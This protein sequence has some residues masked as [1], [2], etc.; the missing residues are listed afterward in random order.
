MP[1]AVRV[2]SGI[3]GLV[4]WSGAAFC[5]AWAVVRLLGLEWG[6][7]AIQLLAFT[8]YVAMMALAGAVACAVLRRKAPAV[9]ALVASLALGLAIAPRTISDGDEVPKGVPLRV[10][11]VNLLLGGADADGV[12]DL[13]RRTKADLVA[14]QE[15]TD[16]A[17]GRLQAAGLLTLL[18]YASLH[19]VPG[20]HGSA[21]YSRSPMTDTGERRHPSGFVQAQG[22]LTVPGAGRLAVESVHPCAPTSSLRDKCWFADLRDQPRPTEG[23]PLRLLLGDFNATLDHAPMRELLD[24]GYRDAAEE[25]G[26]GLRPTWPS[27]RWPPGVTI[28]RALLGPG[29]VARSYEVHPVAGSDHRAVFA[30]VVLPAKR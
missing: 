5:A 21:L 8:P 25:L 24:A 14:F 3:L 15:F 17:A 12:V 16:G 9:L 22:E 2:I 27:D 23:G 13:V 11:S 20:S 6:Y 1:T 18:P 30:E 28:D 26:E 19:P 29:I 10:L 4:T 7:P